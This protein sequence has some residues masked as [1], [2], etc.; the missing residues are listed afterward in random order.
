DGLAALAD[1]FA[2]RDAPP[3]FGRVLVR[4]EG[5]ALP[6]EA[7]FAADHLA[8]VAVEGRRGRR[9]VVRVGFGFVHR[10]GLRLPRCVGLTTLRAD[11]AAWRVW[12]RLRFHFR[13]D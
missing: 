10:P 13:F 7:V 6:V 4:L 3:E 1:Q 11:D 9:V 5:N 2:A 12:F 8:V